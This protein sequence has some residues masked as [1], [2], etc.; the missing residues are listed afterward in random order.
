M[1][2]LQGSAVMIDRRLGEVMNA[3]DHDA[4]PTAATRGRSWRGSKRWAASRHGPVAEMGKLRLRLVTA[5]FRGT[6]ALI[7][8]LGMRV[9]AAFAAFVLS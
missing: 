4:R 6:E 5:G 3:A 1:R 2:L 7:I 8:F 9:G